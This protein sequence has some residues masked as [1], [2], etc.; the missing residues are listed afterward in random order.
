[1]FPRNRRPS[2]DR[3]FGMAIG[4]HQALM[5]GAIVKLVTKRHPDASEDEQGRLFHEYVQNIR[6]GIYPDNKTVK[7]L[8]KGGHIRIDLDG[9][10]V[11]DTGI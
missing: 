3:Q 4:W 7:I 6:G 2:T 5:I 10:I 1:M 8:H 11:E 9:N